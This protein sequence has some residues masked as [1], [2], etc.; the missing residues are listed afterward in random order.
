MDVLKQVI[1]SGMD[2]L[3]NSASLLNDDG[4]AITHTSV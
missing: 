4:I 1:S 3:F 2:R